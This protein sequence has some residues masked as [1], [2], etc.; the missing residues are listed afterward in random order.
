MKLH[1][2]WVAVVLSFGGFSIL[3]VTVFGVDYLNSQN[4]RHLFQETYSKSMECRI[5]YKDREQLNIDIVCGEVPDIKD[6][7]K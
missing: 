5:A 7:V 3:L 1:E 6:F 4:Q 2:E